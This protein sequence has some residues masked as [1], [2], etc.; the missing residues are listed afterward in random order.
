MEAQFDAMEGRLEELTVASAQ[1]D[2][3]A[4]VPRWQSILKE[5]A[6]GIGHGKIMDA[7]AESLLYVVAG[8]TLADIVFIDNGIECLFFTRRPRLVESGIEFFR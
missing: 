7:A 4:D 8:L 2:I 6:Q 5:I 3:I 1:P